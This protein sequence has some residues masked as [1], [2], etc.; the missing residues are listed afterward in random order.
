MYKRQ[1]KHF[2]DLV[3]EIL[4][5]DTEFRL[6]RDVV[7]TSL[8]LTCTQDTHVPD[9]LT[10]IRVLQSVAVVGQRE[11]VVRPEKGRATLV[12]YVKYLPSQTETLYQSIVSLSKKIK[13][14]PGVE[15]ISVMSIDGK[16]VI[17]KGEKI[18]V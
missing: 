2:A 17:Y 8:R 3:S 9:L 10:R 15:V 14:L 12:I 6:K 7:K 4:S 16:P 18:V 5:E 1:K 13:S 11:R